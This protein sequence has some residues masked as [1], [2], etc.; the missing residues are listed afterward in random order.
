MQAFEQKNLLKARKKSQGKQEAKLQNFYGSW[1]PTNQL[2]QYENQMA[3]SAIQS[4]PSSN[5][6]QQKQLQEAE[7]LY[8][9]ITNSY[10]ASPV[11]GNLTNTFPAIPLLSQAQSGDLRHQPLLSG[12]E[13]SPGIVNP[14]KKSVDSVKPLTMTPQEKFVK[15]RRRQQLQAMLAIQKQQQQQLGHQV[16]STN[17]SITRNC[18]LEMQSRS[19]D[20]IDPGIEDLSSLPAPDPPIEQDDSN[21]ISLAVDDY[22]DEDTILYRLQ[23]IISK[24]RLSC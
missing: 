10:V 21:A 3:P 5:L 19:F 18:P 13:L 7:T 14:V 15:L 11:Y 4:S 22:F 23:D 20:G 9:N 1:S 8:Q 6:G 16:L 24:V 17:E 12:D 2:R